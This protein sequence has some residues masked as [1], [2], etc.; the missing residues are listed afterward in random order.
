M[1]STA[2]FDPFKIV[3]G[4]DELSSSWD[5]HL[6]CLIVSRSCISLNQL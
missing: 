1:A 5:I 3:L 2:E 6:A 4:L